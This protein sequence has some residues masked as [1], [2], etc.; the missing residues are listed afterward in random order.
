M[1]YANRGMVSE[2]I[3]ERTCKQY[4]ER[5]LAVITKVP[6]PVTVLRLRGNRISDGFYAKKGTV[7][8]E[9]T[10]AG[11]RSIA[12]DSKETKSKNLPLDNIQKHQLDYLESVSRMN[13]I[14]FILVYFSKLDTYYRLD[15]KNLLGYVKGPWEGNKKSIPLSFFETYATEVKSNNGLYLDFL[16]GLF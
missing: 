11:G 14:A 6:T 3:V 4:R 1:S 12:F 8:F 15:I 7:D 16:E 10:L 5:N 9:G 2:N 13:G